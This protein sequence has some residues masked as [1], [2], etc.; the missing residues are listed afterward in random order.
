MILNVEQISS[1]RLELCT[2]FVGC[3]PGFL[4]F[5]FFS[6]FYLFFLKN[7]S[8]QDPSYLVRGMYVTGCIMYVYTL[9][10][11]DILSYCDTIGIVHTYR[12]PNRKTN[13]QKI[14]I[15]RF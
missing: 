12:Y 3:I 7:L 5:S 8:E 2:R 11:Y 13:K 1:R 9:G 6:R 10:T 15:V 4:S 14:C